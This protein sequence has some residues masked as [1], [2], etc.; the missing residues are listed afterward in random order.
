[1]GG[2]DITDLKLSTTG[3]DVVDTIELVTMWK[4]SNMRRNPHERAAIVDR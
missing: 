2:D 3:S 1:M 4:C